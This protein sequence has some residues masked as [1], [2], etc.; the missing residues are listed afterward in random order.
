MR[1]AFQGFVL[2][3]NPRF[4]RLTLLVALSACTPS[5]P[6]NRA[7]DDG[8]DDK[9][10][11]VQ[12]AL[13][14]AHP[15]QGNLVQIYVSPTTTFQFFVD[16]AS[17]SAGEDGPIRYIMIARSPSGAENLSYEGLRC[18]T[19]ERKLYAFGRSD[20]TWSRARNPQWAPIGEGQANRQHAALA[21]DFFCPQGV[22]V[23]TSED[24][25]RMLRQ[26]AHSGVR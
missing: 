23:R 25:V 19:R 11:E 26:G 3:G 16:T 22:R 6:P 7:S 10:W 8:F 5:S 17:I 1:C 14:P 24:A 9:P 21:E 15:N 2:R 13:L 4:V 20:G 12:Q 18:E